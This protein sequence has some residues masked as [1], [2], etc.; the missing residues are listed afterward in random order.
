M[1][2]AFALTPAVA[3]VIGVV[4]YSKAEGRK[5]YAFA[6]AKLANGEYDC[7]RDGMY[8]FLQ[9][10]SNRVMEFGWDDE[11]GGILNIPENPY[12]PTSDTNNLINNYGSISLGDTRDFKET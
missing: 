8:Q 1:A 10:L 5:L 2:T 6:T 9:S 7:K 4:D 12:D 3:V 11:I